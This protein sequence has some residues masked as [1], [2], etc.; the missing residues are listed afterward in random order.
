MGKFVVIMGVD[1]PAYKKSK[2]K[3][4]VSS[5]NPYLTLVINLYR[6]MD[7][8][9]P[10]N[11]NRVVL[12]RL[13]MSRAERPPMCT[14]T[15]SK[16]MQDSNGVAVVVGT[17]TD[18]GRNGYETLKNIKVCALRFT[19]SSRSLILEAGGVCMTFDQLALVAPRGSNCILLRGRNTVRNAAKR[20]GTTR[21]RNRGSQLGCTSLG[22]YAN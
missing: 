3:S 1:A 11:F 12:K 10:S 2:S 8:R 22:C 13:M 17:V 14:S 4:V 9:C 21:M 18:D 19:A 6:F 15:L 7:R 20:R 5:G 16:F